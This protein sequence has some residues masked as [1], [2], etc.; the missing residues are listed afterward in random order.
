MAAERRDESDCRFIACTVFMI[1]R[2]TR[3]RRDLTIP[4]GAVAGTS[5]SSSANTSTRLGKADA[6]GVYLWPKRVYAQPYY[7]LWGPSFY[8]PFWGPPYFWAPPVIIVRGPP[9]A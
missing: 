7:D 5:D 6:D 3:K 4:T 2:F 1:R 8:D 9:H